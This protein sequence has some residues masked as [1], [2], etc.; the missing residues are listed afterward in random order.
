MGFGVFA[1]TVNEKKPEKLTGYPYSLKVF[2]SGNSSD[3]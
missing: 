3:L 2:T 1:G